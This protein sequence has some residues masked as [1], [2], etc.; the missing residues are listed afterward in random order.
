MSWFPKRKKKKI[1]SVND[2]KKK[3][4]EDAIKTQVEGLVQMQDELKKLET[5]CLPCE[6]PNICEPAT[7]GNVIISDPNCDGS[8]DVLINDN[9]NSVVIGFD[10]TVTDGIH[11]SWKWFNPE[12]G[13]GEKI[14]TCGGCCPETPA[15]TILKNFEKEVNKI[16]GEK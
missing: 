6:P 10:P 2:L 11:S 14:C 1:S 13:I 8:V 7:D 9:G 5:T 15:E 12:S 16:L 4:W 3:S